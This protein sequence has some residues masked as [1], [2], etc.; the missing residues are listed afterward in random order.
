MENSCKSPSIAEILLR[1]STSRTA[2]RTSHSPSATSSTALSS[3]TSTALRSASW[4]L[5]AP[6]LHVSDSPRSMTTSRHTNMRWRPQCFPLSKLTTFHSCYLQ[7]R[8]TSTSNPECSCQSSLL[9]SPVRSPMPTTPQTLSSSSGSTPSNASRQHP[10]YRSTSSTLFST[11]RST[12]L[13]AN[14]I[15]THQ[16]TQK[17]PRLS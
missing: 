12:N 8:Y 6:R 16:H 10:S 7:M 1:P 11:A 15:N 9:T 5:T 14:A 13:H 4:H 17:N 3:S 2:P